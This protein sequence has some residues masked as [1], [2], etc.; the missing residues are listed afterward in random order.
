M[1]KIICIRW[2]T[3]SG[4]GIPR[5]FSVENDTVDLV[6]LFYEMKITNTKNEARRLI[7]QGAVKVC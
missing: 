5:E 3:E 4:W 6:N 1:K 7:K 2:S